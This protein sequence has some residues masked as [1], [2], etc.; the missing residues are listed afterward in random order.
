[1]KTEKRTLLRLISLALACALCLG[2]L[3]GFAEKGESGANLDAAL[4]FLHSHLDGGEKDPDTVMPYQMTM[5][6]IQALNPGSTV[7]DIYNNQGYLSLLVG[8]F[9]DG[10][11]ED[12]ED[13]ILS[14][15]GMASLLGFGKG[16]EFYAVYKSRNNMGYTF[17]TYQQRYGG[18]TLR[19]A[20]L[21][22]AVDPDGYTAGLS[23]SFVPNA[24]TEPQ[25]PVIGAA[26]AMR[27]VQ[28]QYSF[29]NL[30]V[31]RDCTVR[32]A[33][34]FG[35]RVFNCW[36]V[37]TDNPYA[38]SSFDMPYLEHFVT[39][40]GEYVCNMP[41]NMFA[42]DTEVALD[43]SAYFDVMKAETYRTTVTLED[44]SRRVLEVP[45]SYNENDGK[46]YLIDPERKIAV[47]QY[48]DFNYNDY[49]L[50][51]VTSDTVDGWP[52]NNLLA[53]AN[54]IIMYDF[55]AGYG[56]RSVDGFETPILITVGWCD[57]KG[58]AVDNACFYGVI[59]G[60][61]CFGVSDINH[62]SDCLDIV[63][64]EYTHGITRQSVQGFQYS[65]VTGAISEA[66][67]DIMGNL[68]E[69]SLGYTADRS[70]LVGEKAGIPLRNMGSPNEY[71]QPGFVGDRYYKAAVLAPLSEANDN[72]GVH[73]NSSL[74]GRIAYLMDQTDM[75]YEE[76]ISMWLM[77]IEMLTPLSDYS[78]LHGAL[79]FSLKMNGLLEKYGPALNRAFEAA[80]LNE[81]W[82]RTYMSVEKEGC[83]RVT[84]R[85]SGT[86][87]QLP[88]IVAF[89]E[90]N[91]QYV[92]SAYT[93]PDGA[94]SALLAA[95]QYIAAILKMNDDGTVSVW[96]YTANGW[97]DD[98]NS[99]YLP[100]RVKA[101][102]TLEFRADGRQDPG[103]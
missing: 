81:D 44:G 21:R 36:V 102:T 11:V 19:N 6:D 51:F 2:A 86:A 58:R 75:N 45:V 70:W 22:V 91:G 84:V 92:D 60:W 74:L 20:T 98:P 97:S 77:A 41:A 14:I 82:D 57:E 8:K 80:G 17:Y 23:C 40:Y 89:Y 64:H 26:E 30:T 88:V 29:L 68:A 87:A 95:G 103:I 78:D 93:D 54:Y 37:Y 85:L 15:R 59:N 9:Y 62:M 65:N 67:S 100:F 96:R 25:D 83:G 27:I 53:Y 38:T 16:C 73:D 46:Y 39:T 12:M 61:A 49:A 10:K 79:L 72:G 28:Q 99:L 71:R 33:L 52:Q 34:P 31:Y 5:E 47:A 56:I 3:P 35:N 7:I 32:M 18:Y 55:Y 4:N 63:G 69:M 48:Y 101:G 1:M 42:R 50:N 43:N 76:Q 90:T 66:Y 13:G 24:G 94:A